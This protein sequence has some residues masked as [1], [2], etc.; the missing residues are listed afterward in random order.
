MKRVPHHSP[1]SWA[2]APDDSLTS[3]LAE[4]DEARRRADDI[5][6]LVAEGNCGASALHTAQWQ[7]QQC[8][9]RVDRLRSARDLGGD[10][11]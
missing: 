3:A 2:T 7:V 5:A 6:R 8:L 10:A 9:R 1:R 11:A 4:L